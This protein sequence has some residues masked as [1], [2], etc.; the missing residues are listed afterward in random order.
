MSRPL[1]VRAGV[2]AGV[3]VLGISACSS[4]KKTATPSSASTSAAAGA[5]APSS[6]ATSAAP[7]SATPA[8]SASGAG[9]ATASIKVMVGGLSKQIYLPFMLA[10]ELG[11]YDQQGVNVTLLDE[12][13]GVDAETDMLAGKVDAVGGFYDHNIALQGKGK[14]TESVVSMLT[15]RRARSSCAAP[16]S[17][18]RSN[19]LRTGRAGHLGITDLGSSTDFLTQY[20]ATKNGVDREQTSMNSVSRPARHSS[21]QWSTRQI[22]CGDDNRAD[23]V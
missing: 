1:W 22:D 8:T 5:S 20:L 19:R 17:R 4:S 13:A 10:K 3:A 18:A 14:S 23:S 21:L 12:P 2:L 9:G 16:I 15:D 11:Y 6:A 7:A